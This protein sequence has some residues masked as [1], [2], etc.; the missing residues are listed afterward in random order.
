MT[1]IN[2]IINSQDF[3]GAAKRL[4]IWIESGGVGRWELELDNISGASQILATNYI[5]S[6]GINGTT[7]MAGYVDDVKPEV[8][9]ENAVFSKYVTCTGRNYGRDLSRLF[10]IKDYVNKKF[11]DI[12][13][14]ALSI[15][16]SE[17]T[18]TSPST[19]DIVS[20]K[21]NRTYLQ[22][23]F[24]E[25]AKL[26]GYDFCVRND[27]SLQL[28]KLTNA[29]NSGVLLKAL[30]NDV[31]NNI[32]KIDPE[33]KAG[34]DIYNYIR[35]DAG[36]LKGHWTTGNASDFGTA[37]CT[38]IDDT[39]VAV[40]EA[41]I[42]ATITDDA[43]AK[44][45]L[46]FPIYNHTEID[47]SLQD[48]QCELWFNH[49]SLSEIYLYA[50]DDQNHEIACKTVLNPLTTDWI[51]GTFTLGP[52]AVFRNLLFGNPNPGEW[53]YL[54]GSTFTW[55][56]KRIGVYVPY[57][58]GN[59]GTHIWIDGLT[60]DGV[61]VWAYAQDATSISTYGKAM[62]PLLR[63]D[64]KS[65]V[66]LQEITD[67]EL[68]NR[69]NPI[70]KLKLICT[71]Q[72]AI[73]YPGY[74]VDVLA[75]EAYIGY[76]STP[77]TYRILS[78]H[79]I[80]TPGVS[81]CRG[82]DAV[83]EL[84]L[85][86]HNSGIGADPTRF[87]LS[88][89]A[90]QTTQLAIISRLENRVRV[91]ESSFAGSGSVLSGGSG[92][93]MGNGLLN[94]SSPHE[95]ITKADLIN[96]IWGFENG[97]WLPASKTMPTGGS[98]LRIADTL[99]GH[100]TDLFE[101]IIN[102]ETNPASYSPIF[103]V[104]TGFVVKK[105]IS[106]GGFVSANQG[107]IALGSGMTSQFDP[108]GAWLIHSEKSSL[109]DI[110][111]R[112]SAP[113]N[114]QSGQFYINS[115]NNHLYRYNGSSWVDCG[116]KDD[117]AFYFD[118]FYIRRA[119]YSTPIPP[120]AT[121]GVPIPYS[122]LGHLR[123]A[124]ITASNVNPN[125]DN[126]FGL[127]SPSAAWSGVMTY[128][129][130]A[131]AIKKLNGDDWFTS[132]GANF[133][134]DVTITKATPTL[135]LKANTASNP[136]V[137]FYDD[138]VLKMS[139]AYSSSL[140]QLFVYD[141]LGSR[142]IATLNHAG[143]FGA[144]GDIQ[145]G[146]NL[147]AGA[148][149]SVT[150]VVT[151]NLV[152]QKA[153][154]Q[155]SL[156]ANTASDASIL[157]YDAS[158]HKMNLSYQSS[159]D[160]LFL[161]DVLGSKTLAS[162]THN[163]DFGAYRHI[164]AGGDF[165]VSNN[166][167][168]VKLRNGATRLFSD[169]DG[170]LK[171]L[172]SSDVLADIKVSNAKCDHLNSASGTG[173]YLFDH[174]KFY[175]GS[176][177][178]KLYD[179][180]NASGSVGQVLTVNSDGKPQWSAAAGWNGGTVTNNI[181]INS[182][183]PTLAFKTSQSLSNAF[184]WLDFYTN[185]GTR[186]W[187]VGMNIAYDN[188]NFEMISYNNKSVYTNADICLNSGQAIRD[189]SDSTNRYLLLHTSLGSWVFGVHT[190]GYSPAFK[191]YATNTSS[192][193]LSVDMSGNLSVAGGLYTINGSVLTLGQDTKVEH[194]NTVYFNVNSSNSGTVQVTL[195]QAGS[196][197]LILRHYSG[198]SYL[199]SA[200]G[201]LYLAGST[202]RS[203]NDFVAEAGCYINTTNPAVTLQVSGSN[204]IS[205]GFNGSN[206][207]INVTNA[208]DF[209]ITNQN[210]NLSLAASSGYI[211]IGNNQIIPTSGGQGQIGNSTYYWSAVVAR[212]VLP[213]N[214]SSGSLGNTTYWWKYVYLEELW[215]HNYSG[216]TFDDYDDLSLVKLWGEKDAEV[217]DT[218]DSTKIMPPKNDPFNMLKHPEKPEFYSLFDMVSFGL[219]C[220]KALA[221]RY[222]ET[223]ELLLTF[224]DGVEVHDQKIAALETQIPVELERLKSHVQELELQLQALRE[225]KKQDGAISS[226]AA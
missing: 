142:V 149:L 117:A 105:D 223:S 38:A 135:N 11:D 29:P 173:I 20:I 9:D 57:R 33:T 45:Y 130:Y 196:D 100:Y 156:Y 30:A 186:Q 216:H 215:T 221:K 37:N 164:T 52:S 159:T 70:N 202:V 46:Q 65:Q 193:L 109:H 124:N 99:T 31:T 23:G 166:S 103:G 194:A 7:L 3:A 59:T 63:S 119:G 83:T 163:G 167:N 60:I 128:T 58:I 178:L 34:I 222:D 42:K 169:A 96:Y 165:V 62:L 127:G 56:L 17:I 79:H 160:I 72:P 212:N 168:Y 69:K 111:T 88:S 50:M 195:Q 139:L 35:I 120:F 106:C 104:S 107:L 207:F 225:V 89:S 226:E 147:I 61:D 113:S 205:V 49:D 182:S 180:T 68:I 87:K 162:W 219:G 13:D 22:S 224:Y 71:F 54:S 18:Y 98:Y 95:A 64:I 91:L 82:H 19:A 158:V 86:L 74:L 10:I 191:V 6:L 184:G 97:I 152:I 51:K 14:D 217:P 129:L 2:S 220:A 140:D 123:C 145:S 102:E 197:K 26:I 101:V 143:N 53:Y 131:D 125:A 137:T 92:G 55:K 118:T 151:S 170:E 144:F 181:L 67:A 93:Y 172:N 1:T 121:P 27:K 134:T 213:D 203:Q 75:P 94:I 21:F 122:Q 85:V 132:G 25:G 155:L 171:V 161:Y 133:T 32:L 12:V 8:S 39:T 214:S 66:H 174:L 84:E 190:A 41:S 80:A 126:A 114:P 90:P 43:Y 48:R 183:Q 81:I 78:I 112:S 157:F 201:A 141:H 5:V 200:S 76:G 208:G 150:G 199:S 211:W 185:T 16:G 175:N 204:R 218:Y 36:E 108:A 187:L 192:N 110:E 154:P 188:G 77:L 176:T 210:G 153:T 146:G 28:W 24:V 115:T 4:D 116:D 206:S 138:S 148:N 209:G 73:L 44:L 136:T 179:A 40:D 177:G 198:N 47:C 15:A 189:F